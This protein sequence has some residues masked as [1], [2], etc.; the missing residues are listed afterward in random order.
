MINV[1]IIRAGNV[2]TVS[3]G[4]RTRQSCCASASAAKSLESRLTNDK[5][6]ATKWL[7]TYGTSPPGLP[8]DM[9]RQMMKWPADTSPTPTTASGGLIEEEL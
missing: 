7:T 4:K 8:I 6:M 1:S 9:A 3:D 2:I 5:T